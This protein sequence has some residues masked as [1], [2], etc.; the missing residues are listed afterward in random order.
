[1]IVAL[2]ASAA[3]AI[4]GRRT[5]VGAPRG[6]PL[7]GPDGTTLLVTWHPGYI[8][9]TT[10]SR[11]QAAVRTALADDLRLAAGLGG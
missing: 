8:L 10:D 4:A 9:R 5:S 11:A 3:L 1:M 7:A 2:G 6:R